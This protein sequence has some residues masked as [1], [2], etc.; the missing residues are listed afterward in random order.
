LFFLPGSWPRGVRSSL[1]YSARR[2]PPNMQTTSS[3]VTCLSS[4]KL[5]RPSTRPLDKNYGGGPTLPTHPTPPCPRAIGRRPNGPLTGCTRLGQQFALLHI[6]RVSWVLRATGTIR[7]GPSVLGSFRHPVR[8]GCGQRPGSGRG[9]TCVLLY[10]AGQRQG[11][12]VDVWMVACSFDSCHVSLKS[13]PLSLRAADVAICETGN[14]SLLKEAACRSGRWDFPE[15][16]TD[17][18]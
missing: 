17:A 10:T 5:F 6:P 8:H 18:H 7:G 15:S 16:S 2:A 11:S 1:T 3:E 12:G 14:N 4:Q 9:K 13:V